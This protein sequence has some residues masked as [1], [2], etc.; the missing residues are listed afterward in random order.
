MFRNSK[1]KQFEADLNAGKIQENSTVDL[2]FANRVGEQRLT[3]KDAK[4]LAGLLNHPNFPQSVTLNLRDNNISHVG[5]AHLKLAIDA[6]L[7]QYGLKLNLSKSV[8]MTVNDRNGLL[9][10]LDDANHAKTPLRGISS[11]S[12]YQM[13]G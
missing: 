9:A 5:A 1:I 4:V 3:D 11:N 8:K 12:L 13:L 6:G 7:F 2:K 10:A